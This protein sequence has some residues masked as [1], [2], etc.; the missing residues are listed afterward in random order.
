MRHGC[1]YDPAIIYDHV[2]KPGDLVELD[3]NFRPAFWEANPLVEETLDQVALR[4]GPLIY[5]AESN[6]LPAGVR[7]SDVAIG[8]ADGSALVAATE[9]IAGSR[10]LTLSGSALEL[11]RP[12]WDGTQLYREATSEPPREIKLKFVPYYA[13]GNRGDTEMTVWLPRR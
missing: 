5:C 12:A 13:W 8:A 9:S 7:L 4:H 1:L 11:R 6:D 10:V 3:L 2:W